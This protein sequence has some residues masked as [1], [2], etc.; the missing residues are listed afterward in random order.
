VRQHQI[1]TLRIIDADG[2]V[3]PGCTENRVCVGLHQMEGV[4]GTLITYKRLDPLTWVRIRWAMR[5]K[6]GRG[7]SVIVVP[8]QLLDG[9]A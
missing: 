6:I 8:T 1:T 2:V 4:P 7:E 3:Q 5:R 9:G